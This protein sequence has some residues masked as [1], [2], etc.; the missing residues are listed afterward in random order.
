MCQSDILWGGIFGHPAETRS[1]R[2]KVRPHRRSQ[3]Y[4][5]VF[6]MTYFGYCLLE[7]IKIKRNLSREIQAILLIGRSVGQNS[8][9]TGCP[10]PT[11]SSPNPVRAFC[12][13]NVINTWEVGSVS[14]CCGTTYCHTLLPSVEITCLSIWVMLVLVRGFKQ[15]QRWWTFL[16]RAISTLPSGI[17]LFW[18]LFYFCYTM[19]RPCEALNFLSRL[20]PNPASI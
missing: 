17:P 2:R 19:S 12:V 4:K 20:E 9:N 11:V 7:G 18:L 16:F 10:G 6:S 15:V 14:V 3:G 8:R 1:D 5:T 13:I